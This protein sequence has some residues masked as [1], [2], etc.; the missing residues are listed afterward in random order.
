MASRE[1]HNR[2]CERLLGQSCD[3][4]NAWLDEEFRRFGPLHRFSRHHDRGVREAEIIYG[5]WSRKAALVHI[6]KDCGHIPTAVMWA[7]HEVDSLGMI[8][9]GRFNGF[10]DPYEFDRAARA[11]LDAIE[12]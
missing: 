6:L 10:W 8:P 11:L 5:P 4:V 12:K 3:N 7:N 2:D 9:G 1:E